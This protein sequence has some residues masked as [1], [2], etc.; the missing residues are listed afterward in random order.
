MAQIPDLSYD[1]D[2]KA[3]S[4]FRGWTRNAKEKY[5][6]WEVAIDDEQEITEE[7]QNKV[8]SS[9]KTIS[10]K[11]YLKKNSIDWCIGYLK[12]HLT[13]R[14]SIVWSMKYL[15][16]PE[17]Y[18]HILWLKSITMYLD[19]DKLTLQ[20]INRLYAYLQQTEFPFKKLDQKADGND[21]SAH[22]ILSDLQLEDNWKT[23]KDY[24]ENMIYDETLKMLEEQKEIEIPD[25]DEYFFI[26]ELK[27]LLLKNPFEK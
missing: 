21:F 14:L 27:E 6:A 17:R 1:I 7:F 4:V 16:K 13:S 8:L 11:K 18:H 15:D 2:K 25:L 12:G 20:R 9:L 26:E 22:H 5:P 19:V 3:F 10:K 23:N 24:L